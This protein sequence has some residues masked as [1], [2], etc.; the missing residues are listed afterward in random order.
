MGHRTQLSRA[1][2]LACLHVYGAAQFDAF[3]DVLGYTRRD[4]PEP[5]QP[6]AEREPVTAPSIPL[7]APITPLKARFYRVVAQLSAGADR[8]ETGRTGLVSPGRPVSS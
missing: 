6:L 4:L 7:Q 5:A 8:G 2:L 1:D 3:A